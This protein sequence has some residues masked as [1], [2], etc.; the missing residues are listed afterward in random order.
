MKSLVHDHVS[1]DS[2]TPN[3]LYLSLQC[4][5]G[6][7][8]ES[9]RLYKMALKHD[10]NNNNNG[11]IFTPESVH[12]LLK[13]FIQSNRT[14]EVHELYQK[15]ILE[16]QDLSLPIIVLNIVLKSITT[17]QPI[18]NK[19]AIESIQLVECAIQQGLKPHHSTFASLFTIAVL[20]HSPSL[21]PLVESL[22]K[23][24][25]ISHTHLTRSSIILACS[26]IEDY[27]SFFM[28][29][30][31][32]IKAR[33][34]P[35]SEV[36]I[37]VVSGLKKLGE[38]A[39]AIRILEQWALQGGRLDWDMV[40]IIPDITRT[41]LRVSSRFISDKILPASN[42]EDVSV[43]D[44]TVEVEV[45]VSDRMKSHLDYLNGLLVDIEKPFVEDLDDIQRKKLFL[46][47]LVCKVVINRLRGHQ[48]GLKTSLK[49]CSELSEVP[50][51]IILKLLSHIT[52]RGHI[53]LV[54]RDLSIRNSFQPLSFWRD[55]I[56]SLLNEY[57][58]E[59]RIFLMVWERVRLDSYFTEKGRVTAFA[60]VIASLLHCYDIN[61]VKKFIESNKDN[62]GLSDAAKVRE[63]LVILHSSIMSKRLNK[64]AKILREEISVYLEPIASP[65]TDETTNCN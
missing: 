20:S 63:I 24:S 27:K 40:R 32:M 12:I 45:E 51:D 53:D 8:Q 1:L 16:N 29:Y 10:T 46:I 58:R 55:L 39:I 26:N 62:L 22:M 28:A 48:I 52:I 31:D 5:K 11:T 42:S 23:S 65:H 9:L 30:D 17:L 21:I 18:S 6:D 15:V 35:S 44:D 36:V 25:G 3:T 59:W 14:E 61:M 50:I 33:I 56:T 7:I 57:I 54:I 47:D 38:V 37:S 60:S 4:V 19:S 2:L 13:S 43:S 41:G 34:L 49:S 64:E